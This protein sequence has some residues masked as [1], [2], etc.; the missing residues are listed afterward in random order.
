MPNIL[1]IAK[2]GHPIL[3]QKAE[4]VDLNKLDQIRPLV[5]DMTYTVHS[6]GER[7][8]L[9]APQ[10]FQSLRLFIFRIPEK[11]HPRYGGGLL[12]PLPMHEV[13]NPE[14]EVLSDVK[15]DGYEAC[16]S[17]P[18]LMGE[19]SRWEHIAYHYYDLNGNKHSM[20]AKGFHARVI[21]HEFDH[22][23]GILFPQRM[24]NLDSFGYEDVVCQALNDKQLANLC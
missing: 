6:M 4:P 10:V 8:G 14:I 12:T 17:V 9:A 16:I 11:L 7:I 2:M 24:N 1:P 21:Q 13:I 18:G 15:I 20:E 22:L 5:E 19:V 3:K 23:D